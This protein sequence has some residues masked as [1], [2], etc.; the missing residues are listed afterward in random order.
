MFGSKRHRIIKLCSL[1]ISVNIFLLG[2]FSKWPP[3]RNC[4][5]TRLIAPSAPRLRGFSFTQD[6]ALITAWSATLRTSSAR[7]SLMQSPP[8]PRARDPATSRCRR[9]QGAGRRPRR[10]HGAGQGVDHHGQGGPVARPAGRQ[11]VAPEPAG[12]D[13]L[14][15]G[16]VRRAVLPR[17]RPSAARWCAS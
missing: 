11:D 2:W 6:C 4:P 10:D 17:P 13:C 12:G 5:L 3:L 1:T 16:R 15:G 9:R 8:A 7:P 14:G